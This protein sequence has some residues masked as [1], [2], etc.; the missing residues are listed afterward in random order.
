VNKLVTAMLALTLIGAVQARA[1]VRPIEDS[2]SISQR[3]EGYKDKYAGLT[4]PKSEFQAGQQVLFNLR[5]KKDGNRELHIDVF[6]PVP[7]RAKH[8]GIL[9]VHGGG[10]RSG[11]KS[12]F[13]AIANLLAQRGY[14]VFLPE[15]RLSPESL[16]PQGLIDVN[17]AIVWAKANAADFG[18]PKDKL[19]IGGASSGGQM[20]SLLA[21][22]ADTPLF[23]TGASDDTRANALVDLD[24][25]LDFTTPM[26]LQYENAAGSVASQWLGGSMEQIPNTWR[27]ASAAKHV[28]AKSPPTLI[29]S[30]GNLRFTAGREDVISALNGFGIRSQYFEFKNA[31]HDVWLFE[32][33][34]TQIVDKVDGFLQNK[35]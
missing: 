24:G 28:S 32:P 30:S 11:D 18:I 3:Y 15:Y 6:L 8:Q 19:A 29:I 14:A 23:K 7:A 17:D 4:L 25:V 5:Y 21:Y 9:L 31:P 13:Y 26:A 35:K 22:T 33:Y 20:A 12:H 27:E 10:W 2:Y 34:L 1:D 16:Y